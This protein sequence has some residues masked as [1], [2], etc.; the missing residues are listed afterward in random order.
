MAFSDFWRLDKQLANR[1]KSALPKRSMTSPQLNALIVESDIHR[2]SRIRASI[3]EMSGLAIG[4]ENVY[5]WSDGKN[6][7]LEADWD[8]VVARLS[9]PDA[10]GLD[11]LVDAQARQNNLPVIAILEGGEPEAVVDAA[12]SLA[13]ECL[14]WEEVEKGFLS[15]QI[16]HAL[17]RGEMLKELRTQQ[18]FLAMIGEE[19]KYRDLIDRIDEAVFVLSEDSGSVLFANETAESWFG[20]RLGDTLS[21]LLEYDLRKMDSVEM[22]ISIVNTQTSNV[23]LKSN[24]LE[25][26]GQSACMIALKDI[27]KQKKAEE[28]FQNSRRQLEAICELVESADRPSEVAYESD[29]QAEVNRVDPGESL[30]QPGKALV[31]DD[32]EVL[33]MV[34]KSILGAMGFETIVASDGLE[35][36]RLY[37]EHRDEI[38][39][40]I[41]DLNMPGLNGGGVFREIR[42]DG[43]CIPILL[44]SGMND[45]DT[46]PF[47]DF[48]KEN[49]RFLMKPFGAADVREAIDLLIGREMLDANR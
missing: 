12:R 31:V 20:E 23:A 15:Q 44:T 43:R 49:S 47:D 16:P 28:A 33:R 18:S 3:E 5:C 19:S 41:V 4:C 1:F 27:S 17:E 13:D 25:W 2:A 35:A 9:L 26:A 45:F 7:L 29:S 22:E 34:L 24:R 21:D 39:L 48:E 42:E 37:E 36:V 6:R 14:F 38:S 11:V 46:L 32:E 30:V 8:F 40:A 10:R